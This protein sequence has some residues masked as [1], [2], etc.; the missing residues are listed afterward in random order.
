[1]SQSITSIKSINEPLDN[2]IYKVKHI[3]DNQ[4]QTIYV[5]YGR[6]DKKVSQEQLIKNIFSDK[7]NDEI[8]KNKSKIIFCSQRIHPDDSI[9]TI[10]IKIINE[11]IKKNVSI[12]ELYLFCKKVEKLNSIS[13]YQ[14][15]TQNKHISLTKV[16]LDQFLYNINSSLN[17][18]TIS[19]PEDKEIYT[20]DDIFEM[21]LDNKEFVIDKVLGQKF[22]VVENEYP[23]VCNP[24]NVHEYDKFLEKNSRKSLS[25]LNNHLLLNSGEIVDNSIYLCLASEVLMF[26]NNNDI[27]EETA[28]KIYYPFLYNKNKIISIQNL[29]KTMHIGQSI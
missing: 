7:E 16:R 12:D 22:F 14:S 26:N 17:G 8:Q 29:S 9:L 18:E 1:M 25:T 10:K 20:Y 4:I 23:F 6:K 19:K 15:L 27:S 24:Y 5:F 21:K 28:L 2:I 11:L 13:V 3:V